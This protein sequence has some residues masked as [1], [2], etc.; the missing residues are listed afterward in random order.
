MSLRVAYLLSR[1]PKLSETF[2]VDEIR[3]L[4]RADARVAIYSLL[5]GR[6]GHAES[7]TSDLAAKVVTAGPASIRWMGAQLYWL[8]RSPARLISV[9]TRVLT[10]HAGSPREL[11]R[12]VVAVAHG[13]WFARSMQRD[14]IETIHAHWATHTA[15][16]AWTIHRLTGL[17]YSFTTHADD[18]FVR[19]PMLEEKVRDARWV[20]T[21]SDYNRRYLCEELGTW[22][23]RKLR[24]VRCGVRTGELVPQPPNVG[25]KFNIACIARLEPKKGHVHLLDA[26]AELA[27]RRVSFRCVIAGDGRER[28]AL[29]Q[30]VHALGLDDQVQLLGS[31]PRSR[32]RE[33]LKACH[34]VV[35]PCVVAEGGRA[36]GIPVCLMEAMALARPV[37]TTPVSGIPE[38]VEHEK[39]GLLVAPADPIALADALVRLRTDPALCVQL[40]TEGRKRV[41]QEYDVDRNAAQ[42]LSLFQAGAKQ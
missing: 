24:V 29:E 23:E 1:F 5:P 33:V 13:S 30:R 22:A 9:W 17:P 11:V 26:C 4:E 36:D 2:V 3:A 14:D 10:T 19:R 27:R 12:A 41:S 32:V 38:L 16:A 8:A 39:T 6:S 18:I 15:L 34:A 37:V 21:I 28:A 35:L 7:G 42:L 20:V 25:E 31:I 40:A